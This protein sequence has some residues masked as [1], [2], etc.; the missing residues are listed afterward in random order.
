MGTVGAFA[1]YAEDL[2]LYMAGT[3]D[4]VGDNQTALLLLQRILAADRQLR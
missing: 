1:L 4:E 2:D 3:I